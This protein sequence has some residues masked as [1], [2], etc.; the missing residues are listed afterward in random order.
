L[1][2]ITPGHGDA[3]WSG[4]DSRFLRAPGREKRIDYAISLVLFALGAFV[5]AGD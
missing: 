5:L 4:G 1:G 3:S 2:T